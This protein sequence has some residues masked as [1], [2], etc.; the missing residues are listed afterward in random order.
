MARF[1]R[2]HPDLYAEAVGYL[3][4][5]SGDL[6]AE[7]GDGTWNA[8]IGVIRSAAPSSQSWRDA[9]RALHD[10]AIA[11]GIPGGIGLR[12]TM[13]GFPPPVPEPSS[14]WICPHG[15]CTRVQLR[16]SA[17]SPSPEVPLCALSAQPMR[18]VK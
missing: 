5:N 15:L 9:V 1:G 16:D 7:I 6:R 4:Q 17:Q 18:L 12:S 11:A 10:T 3:C 14:G 2:K 8:S 13:G